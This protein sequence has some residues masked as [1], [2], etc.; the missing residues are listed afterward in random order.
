ML[1]KVIPAFEPMQQAHLIERLRMQIAQERKR[2]QR[3]LAVAAGKRGRREDGQ[4]GR[5]RRKRRRR[6]RRRVQ[7]QNGRGS[8]RDGGEDDDEEEDAEEEEEEDFARLTDAVDKSMVRCYLNVTP[9]LNC[10]DGFAC[11]AV[12]CY[13]TGAANAGKEVKNLYVAPQHLRLPADE[14]EWDSAIAHVFV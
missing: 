3:Q 11:V 5:G 10:V 9:V 2:A 7:G 1:C 6:I 13:R 4:E 14:R 12:M 8:A